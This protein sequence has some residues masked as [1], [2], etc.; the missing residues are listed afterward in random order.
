ML[1]N[2]QIEDKEANQLQ[3]EIDQ[4][5]FYLNMHTPTI[6]LM[7]QKTKIAY[8]SELSEIFDRHELVHAVENTDF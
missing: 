2:G 6:E 7:D 3:G 1:K 8:Y 4:K 5:I